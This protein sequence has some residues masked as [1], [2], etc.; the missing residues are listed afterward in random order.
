[1]KIKLTE[2]QLRKVILNESSPI[3]WDKPTIHDD[4]LTKECIECEDYMDEYERDL[5][6]HLWTYKGKPFSGISYKWPRGRGQSR[7]KFKDGKLIAYREYHPNNR[8]SSQQ[9]YKDEGYGLETKGGL[10]CWDEEGIELN[11]MNNE[12]FF[13]SPE[14]KE[15]EKKDDEL[16]AQDIVNHEEERQKQELQDK[17]NFAGGEEEYEKQSKEEVKLRKYPDTFPHDLKITPSNG[18]IVISGTID[19]KFRSNTYRMKHWKQKKG[20]KIPI[21]DITHTPGNLI[22]TGDLESRANRWL[23][24]K[25]TDENEWANAH[26]D[27]TY[28]KKSIKLDIPYYY[29]TRIGDGI[30]SSLEGKSLWT[31]GAKPGTVTLT[32]K[33]V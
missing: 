14:M 15:K 4:E 6:S 18:D 20:E 23:V 29:N 33:K 24:D 10:E 17:I 31:I 3:A 28:G 21:K 25:S 30:L 2:T 9:H 7:W 32:M 12:E 22:L 5:Q 1:M 26:I 19:G 8:V 27:I 16:R 11:C 13:K